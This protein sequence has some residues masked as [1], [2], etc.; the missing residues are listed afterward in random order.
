MCK[1]I[2]EIQ[3][4][5]KVKLDQDTNY[6][7]E[8]AVQNKHEYIKHLMRDSQQKKA[9]YEAFDKLSESTGF[10]LKDFCQKIIPVKFRE[11]QKEYFGKKSVS[12][13]VDILF[14]KVS[15]AQIKKPDVDQFRKDL[16]RVTNLYTKSDNADCCHGN[17]SA[18]AMYILCRQE[19]IRF[20]SY[21]YNYPCFEKN[22]VT[23]KV[24]QLRALS[25]VS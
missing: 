16:P 15:E 11:G 5:V 9:K 4:L 12:L 14:Y 22:N 2:E 1:T 7:V 19:G 17:H 24:L 18:G 20:L 6:D 3:D 10:W 25:E 23:M 13:Y 8:I 21:N